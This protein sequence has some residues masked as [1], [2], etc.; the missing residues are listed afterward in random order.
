MKSTLI[1][2]LAL[3]LTLALVEEGIAVEEKSLHIKVNK[4]K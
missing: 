1:V 2:I 4:S 3:G